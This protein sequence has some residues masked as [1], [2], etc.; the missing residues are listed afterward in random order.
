M[1]SNEELELECTSWRFSVE[2]NNLSP[3]KTIPKE[4]GSYVKDYMM[5]RGYIVDLERVSSEAEIYAMS[6]KLS[7]DGKDVWI[8]YVDDTLLSNL[9]YYVEHCYGLEIFYPVEFDKWVH[10]AMAPAIEP[11]LKLYEKV[12]NL[13]FKVFFLTGRSEKQRSITIENLTE[14][15][16]RSWDKLILRDVAVAARW[17]Y[18]E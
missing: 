9:P 13:G 8:F 7:R 3:W 17:C 6:L 2:T 4:C 10:R 16:F 14:A 18:M 5:G 1:K 12:L 15:G 11:S